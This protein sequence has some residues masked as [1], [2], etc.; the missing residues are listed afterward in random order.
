M[1]RLQILWIGKSYALPK[2]GVKAHRHP[3][4]HMFY[5]SEG[6]GRFIVDNTTHILSAGQCLLVPRNTEHAYINENDTFFK[7]L[8]IKFSLSHPSLD[9]RLQGLGTIISNDEMAGMLF[10]RI[11]QDYA[12]I[13]GQADEAAA[14]YLNALLNILISP[15]R[16]EMK[17]EFRYFDASSYSALS[18]QIIHYLEKNYAK[19]LSLD[20]LAE[21]L[22]YNKSY[23]CVAFKKDTH[24]TILDCLNMIR[25]RRAAELIVYSDHSLAHVA[26]MCGFASDSHFNRVFVKYVGITPGQC[27]RAYPANIV[28]EPKQAIQ[29]T[30]RP[31]RFMYNV[32]AQKCITPQM[33]RDLN[34]QG[35]NTIEE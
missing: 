3:Y 9:S 7:Y 11:I 16:T 31:S 26:A 34:A 4:Y 18:K 19:E 32:L 15:F 17:R 25:I 12:D 24:S 6:Q 33:I 8:E 28:Y 14:A 35:K 1:E 22:Q 20:A 5:I 27:R 13:H 29:P 30:D 21:A 10:E 2:A 23:L